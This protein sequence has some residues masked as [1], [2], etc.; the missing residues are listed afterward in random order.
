[1]VPRD[2]WT[3]ERIRNQ[4]DRL[5]KQPSGLLPTQESVGPV[6][7]TEQVNATEAL[8]PTD[9]KKANLDEIAGSCLDLSQ[10][11]NKNSYK[12]SNS[13]NHFLRGNTENGK[14]HHSR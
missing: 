3:E 7:M 9:Y 13:M 11:S 5:M 2:Y 6:E 10:N 12:F 4:K 8:Q 1:M 14:E